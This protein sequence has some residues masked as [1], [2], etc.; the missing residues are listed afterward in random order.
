MPLDWAAT[1]N[2]LGNALSTLGGRESGTERLEAAVEA[3]REALKAFASEGPP[4]YRDVAQNNL[5][6]ALRKLDER[7]VEPGSDA[8]LN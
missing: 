1:Q 3:Y 6:R 4:R 5:D 2:N 7:A 8:D